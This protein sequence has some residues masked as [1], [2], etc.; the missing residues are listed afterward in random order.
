MFFISITLYSCLAAVI[1]CHWGDDMRK[2][3]YL[4]AVVV[5]LLLP[6]L[7]YRIAEKIMMDK[8]EI[9][10]TH[11]ISDI[12]PA[13]EP[14]G[15]ST[16]DIRVLQQDGRVTP[17]ELETYVAAVLLGEMPADFEL[18]ALKAQA[19]AIRT[20]TMKRVAEGGKHDN[21]DVCMLASCCQAFREPSIYLSQGG[22]SEN[23]EKIEKAIVDTSGQV[24]KYDGALIE[25]TYF[26]SSGGM[27]EDAVAVWGNQVPYLQAVASPEGKNE[28]FLNTVTFSISEFMRLLELSDRP[29][30]VDE[31][32]YTPGGGVETIKFG[33]HEFQGTDFRNKLS[34]ASTDLLITIVGDT[35]TITTRGNGHRVGMSQY[36]AEAMAVAGSMYYEILEHYYPGTV[37]IANG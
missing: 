20:Y 12:A 17:M 3:Y 16:I 35:V 25:A 26:S 6:L 28:K 10:E 23:L 32:T 2:Y 30:A 8:P 7:A 4:T 5:T 18:E 19:V 33:E 34:L 36:G 1:C 29:S 37:L 13:T 22:T 21:A 11:A 15:V 9:P 31:I 14:Y 24:L 27:T